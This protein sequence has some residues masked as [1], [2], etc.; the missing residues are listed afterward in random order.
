[1]S[2]GFEVVFRDLLR[3]SKAFHVRGKDFG[4]IAPKDGPPV[5]HVNEPLLAKVLPQVLRAIGVMHDAVASSMEG[6]SLKLQHAHDVYLHTERK[7][8]ELVAR[9]AKTLSNPEAIE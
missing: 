5:P 9:L 3:A 2:G 6:H 4:D 1:M 7:N 8:K